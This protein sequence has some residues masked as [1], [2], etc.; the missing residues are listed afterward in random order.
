MEDTVLNNIRVPI[1]W[2]CSYRQIQFL[3]VEYGVSA[4]QGCD[5]VCAPKNKSIIQLWNLFK[6]AAFLYEK[7]Y[8]DKANTIYEFVRRALTKYENVDVGSSEIHVEDA[9]VGIKCIG[10]NY[11][12]DDISETYNFVANNEEQLNI[13][14]NGLGQVVQ[15][16]ITSEKIVTIGSKEE[17]FFIGYNFV[18]N[19][20]NDSSWISYN[21][22]NRSVTIREN[23]VSVRKAEFKL[24]Q[25]ESGKI[26]NGI[27]NQ[28]L[29]KLTYK[30]TIN[31]FPER[32]ELPPEGGRA[33]F[34]ID[35]YKELVNETGEIVGDKIQVYYKAYSSSRYFTVK[36]NS[37]SAE[38]NAN[39]IRKGSIIIERDELGI[40]GNKK[41]ELYQDSLNKEIRYRLVASVD[42]NVID[43]KGTNAVTLTVESY[44]ET[45][46]NG[47][48]QGDKV[49][50]PYTVVSNKGLLTNHTSDKNKWY[51]PVNETTSV[52]TDSLT[53]RQ[54]ES[55]KSEVIDIRQEAAVE[56]FDYIFTCNQENIDAPNAGTNVI[57]NIQSFKQFYV[58]NKPSNKT[59]VAYTGSVVSGGDFITITPSL[60]NSITIAKN[61]NE[62]ERN[63]KILYKQ[64]DNN[65]K[66]LEVRITQIG[67]SIEY[68]YFFET[69]DSNEITLAQYANTNRDI[70]IR[71]Y[72]KKKVNGQ[73]EGGN[74]NV[75]FGLT[76]ALSGEIANIVSV[77]ANSQDSKIYIRSNLN[78]TN[79]RYTGNIVVT[80]SE[81][82]NGI[83]KTLLFT[84]IK[85]ASKIEYEYRLEVNVNRIEVDA[86]APDGYDF[87]VTRND[88]VIYIN[89]DHYR[90]DENLHW[91]ATADADWIK[92]GGQD[93]GHFN[94]D[95]NLDRNSKQ[96]GNITV[97]LIDDDG[98]TADKTIAI[99]QNY[100]TYEEK[101]VM[102]VV[103]M[104]ELFRDKISKDLT[105]V[106]E[107]NSYRNGRIVNTVY[108]T[109]KYNG[110]QF[111]ITTRFCE[112]GCSEWN[113]SIN[114]TSQT[115]G[116]IYLGSLSS[117]DFARAEGVYETEDKRY[118]AIISAIY[119][120][121]NS[122]YNPHLISYYTIPYESA[123]YDYFY[124]YIPDNLKCLYADL[125]KVFIASH[126]DSHKLRKAI[127]NINLFQSLIAAHFF[128]MQ[129]KYELF[130][131]MI[132]S[133]LNNWFKNN[134]IS[135]EYHIGEI[136]ENGHV[137]MDVLPCQKQ[138]D[139][140][141]EL[142]PI[143]GH[144]H[145]IDNSK[146]TEAIEFE[147][148]DSHLILTKYGYTK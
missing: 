20:S 108:E 140:K 110:R 40:D 71:S 57:L 104:F 36:G 3:L 38:A 5:N 8:T 129:K 128:K 70:V 58:N 33:S 13:Q 112:D 19:N 131:K 101:Y 9:V 61:D 113:F 123:I 90:T 94:V 122:D 91:Q 141:L 144:L 16:N 50:I 49:T 100:A 77:N 114:T 39:E 111:R 43:N 54:T 121:A 35:S 21:Q 27:I 29:N 116:C 2:V 34:S 88:R 134:D 76:T 11:E 107:N 63:G 109:D 148:E 135:Y 146:D 22:E 15:F 31:I 103:G 42:N 133:Y 89:D 53:I 147:V 41:I 137:Y 64:V 44:K 55:N 74:I 115:V 4:I 7:G 99:T 117:N 79:N 102:D 106:L 84:I 142:D 119:Y 12:F 69:D 96:Y 87:Q 28:D 46:I 56:T 93:V 47:N 10:D 23:K 95:E 92:V 145:E 120:E 52:R 139:V 32:I 105:Y 25:L 97:H 80:Q 83:G 51:M 37:V 98:N 126:N 78:T 136:E 85:E 130:L 17:K 118:K 73:Y 82:S 18:L 45:Y 72:K 48:P 24:I 59:P 125:L 75:N 143:T 60:P 6:N 132:V 81:S 86:Y 127:F 138:A 67:A 1:D 65:S 124:H 14:D 62:K 26:L 68:E 30:Y 66:E